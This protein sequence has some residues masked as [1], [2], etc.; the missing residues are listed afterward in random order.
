MET[1]SVLEHAEDTVHGLF[2][3]IGDHF[4]NRYKRYQNACRT[5]PFE[6]PFNSKTD[7]SGNLELTIFTNKNSRSIVIGRL[8]IWADGYTPAAPY[9]NADGWMG[10]YSNPGKNPASLRDYAP[11]VDGQQF[12]PNVARYSTQDALRF[13]ES[14]SCVLAVYGG[15]PSTNITGVAVGFQ[16]PL[17]SEMDNG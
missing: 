5:I 2:K 3:S 9:S 8:V 10:I 12:L 1:G 11:Y 15:P 14:E 7:T 4:F 17:A 13:R 6:M 16:E